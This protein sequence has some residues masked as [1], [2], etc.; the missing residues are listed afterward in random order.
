[1]LARAAAT[2]SDLGELFKEPGRARWTPAEIVQRLCKLPGIT[3]AVVCLPDGLMVAGQTTG[4]SNAQIVAAFVPQLYARVV[5]YT[6]AMRLK[7]SD[8]LTVIQGLVPIRILKTEA[9]FLA[10]LGAAGETL[11]EVP[12]RQVSQALGPSGK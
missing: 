8:D 10:V 6:G 3:G 7:E 2:P 9:L 4:E 11:A 1:V 12:L 5:Q